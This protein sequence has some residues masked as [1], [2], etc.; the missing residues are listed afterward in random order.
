MLPLA[1]DAMKCLS[2]GRTGQLL[3]LSRVGLLKSASLPSAQFDTVTVAVQM[4]KSE[5]VH[6]LSE[7]GRRIFRL[8][9]PT[10]KR[11][12]QEGAEKGD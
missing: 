9:H 8:V 5:N 2:D 10:F 11:L 6:V 12:L 4:A 3:A 1:E 7:G